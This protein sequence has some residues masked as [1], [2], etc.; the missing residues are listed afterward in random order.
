MS[1]TMQ[2][3]SVRAIA[4]RVA[5]AMLVAGSSAFSALGEER[6][7]VLKTSPLET[8]DVF[9][10]RIPVEIRVEGE[11]GL[12]SLQVMAKAYEGG[13]QITSTGLARGEN[14]LVFNWEGREPSYE[15]VPAQ[16]ELVGEQCRRVDGLRVERA[17]CSFGD[18]EVQ[19]CLD[20]V[21][22]AGASAESPLYIPVD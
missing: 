14:P 13:Q 6:T 2:S 20:H 12:S 17:W 10:C 15:P 8:G 4:T 19:N 3:V 1:A 9:Q 11:R 22:F 7:I 5:V 18:G 16:F 21:R